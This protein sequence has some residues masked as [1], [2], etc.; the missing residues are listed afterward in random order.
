MAMN[1]AIKFSEME[2]STKVNLLNF[3]NFKSCL[4]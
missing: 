2:P 3:T 4:Q 1:Q